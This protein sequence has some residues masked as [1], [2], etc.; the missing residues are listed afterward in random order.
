[1]N[2]DRGLQDPVRQPVADGLLGR[3]DPAAAHV[4][5]DAA[6]GLSGVQGKEAGDG[7]VEGAGHLVFRAQV[8]YCPVVVRKGG[9][10]L[11]EDHPG[12][13]SDLPQARGTG[14]EE[15]GGHAGRAPQTE[16]GNGAADQPHGVVD[17]E[18]VEDVFTV[19]VSP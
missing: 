18:A 13:G 14:G 9:P 19:T 17:R 2:A 7:V 6:E 8:A 16:G 11:V 10:D 5:A 1:M 4:A 3:E 15:D 12:M